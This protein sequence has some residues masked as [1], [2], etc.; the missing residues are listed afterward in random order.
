MVVDAI[1]DFLDALLIVYTILIVAYII[2]SLVFAAGARLPYSRAS[3]AVLTF[4]RQVCEPYLRLFRRFVPP[5]GPIDLSAIVAILT[6]QIVGG[7]LIGLLRS[8]S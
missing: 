4:L 2:S 5:L 3:D 8:L 1:A 6:L 7:L